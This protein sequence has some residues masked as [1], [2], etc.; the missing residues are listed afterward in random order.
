MTEVVTGEAVVL[1]LAVARFP[2]RMIALLLDMIVELPVFIFVEWVAFI[3]SAQH[4]NTASAAALVTAGYATTVTLL[5]ASLGGQSLSVPQRMTI[6]A[7]QVGVLGMIIVAAALGIFLIASAARAV[8][9]GRPGTSPDQPASHEPARDHD[10]VGSADRGE[11]DT[12]V[13]ERTELGA[14][15][16]P[17]P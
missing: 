8:R 3:T 12:V 1:D 17:G 7:T 10:R 6:Q 16:K 15:G 5:L 11:P 2:S 9:R 13:A 4:L 14:V